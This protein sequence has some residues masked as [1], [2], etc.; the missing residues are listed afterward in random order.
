[1]KST[2]ALI[3]TGLVTAVALASPAAAHPRATK[4]TGRIFYLREGNNGQH[5]FSITAAGTSNRRVRNVKLDT[6]AY[7][8]PKAHR[9]VYSVAAGEFQRDLVVASYA[10]TVKHRYR[11]QGLDNLLSVSPNGKYLGVEKST[12]TGRFVF[13]ITTTTGR[14]VATLFHSN[15]PGA[16]ITESWRANSKQVVL[17]NPKLHSSTL[18]IYN[19]HGKRVRTLPK[20]NSQ[21]FGVAWS[22]AG[23]IAY[24]TNEGIDVMRQSGGKPRVLVKSRRLADGGLSYSPNGGYLAYGLDAGNNG[25]IWRVNA[26]GT[27]PVKLTNNGVEPAWG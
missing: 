25:Q 24:S 17:M 15:N 16:A 6:I 2:A 7:P 14:T 11:P 9:I 22:S 8:A 3:A 4:P 20:I 18:T 1:M 26:D 5:E 13:A 27:N 10:G 12:N 19:R 23:D 21:A